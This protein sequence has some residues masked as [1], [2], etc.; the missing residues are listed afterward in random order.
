MPFLSRSQ[1][2]QSADGLSA[3]MGTDS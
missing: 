3:I 1:R 2:C